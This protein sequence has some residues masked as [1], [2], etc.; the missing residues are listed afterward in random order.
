[1]N[2]KNNLF[3][4]LRVIHQ[5]LS[6]VRVTV[7]HLATHS[8][9]GFV[10]V[11]SIIVFLSVNLQNINKLQHTSS[12]SIWK[13][14]QVME[15]F[16]RN[17]TSN[18]TAFSLQHQ[19]DGLKVLFGEINASGCTDAAYS[20]REGHLSHTIGF[21][22]ESQQRHKIWKTLRNVATQQKYIIS[23][24]SIL[25]NFHHINI[26][27]ISNLTKPYQIKILT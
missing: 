20:S 17:L 1:M 22:I 19:S 26:V 11:F 10:N 6:C 4:G 15:L 14:Q 25:R 23:F 16:T 24:N 18:L 7:F 5:D 3:I 12:I 21:A 2:N 13:N 8:N 9:C 27:S